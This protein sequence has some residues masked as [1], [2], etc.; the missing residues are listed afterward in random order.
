M[1]ERDFINQIYATWPGGRS[2]L[3]SLMAT[4]GLPE[5][6]AC[7]IVADREHWLEYGQRMLAI[8]VDFHTRAKI[9][10]MLRRDKPQRFA[11][12]DSDAIV[13]FTSVQ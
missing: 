7:L 1:T 4:V 11:S 3:V 12:S 10:A 8:P 9:V 5:R 2:Q 13:C 6:Y